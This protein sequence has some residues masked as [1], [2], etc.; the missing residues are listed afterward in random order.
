MMKEMVEVIADTGIMAAGVGVAMVTGDGILGRAG[1]TIRSPRTKAQA[2]AQA[3]LLCS[4][5]QL[6]GY[7]CP[8]ACTMF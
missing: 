4:I 1:M 6:V 7:R 5:R 2:Q 3:H 8:I